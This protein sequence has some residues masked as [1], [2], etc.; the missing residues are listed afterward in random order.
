MKT[1]I[2]LMSLTSLMANAADHVISQK[3]EKFDKTT[4]TINV[5]DSVNF[6]N[7]EATKIHNVFSLGPKNMFELQT[8]KPGSSSVIKFNEEGET[9]VECAIHPKMKLKIVVKK[10]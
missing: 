2:F 10:K 4:L 1:V 6:K 3:D 8:Q 9:D 7:D 5:G